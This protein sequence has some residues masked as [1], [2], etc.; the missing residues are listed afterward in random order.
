MD[1]YD[2]DA[3]QVKEIDAE[4]IHL[5]ILESKYLSQEIKKVTDKL[6]L[7]IGAGRGRITK[8][9]LDSKPLKLTCIEK[10]KKTRELLKNRFNNIE[11]KKS[12]DEIY[13][14]YNYII[15]VNTLVHI[16]NKSEVIE[17]IGR[18][19]KSGGKLI[20][21][22]LYQDEPLSIKDS[23]GKE[24]FQEIYKNEFGEIKNKLIDNG[25]KILREDKVIVDNAKAEILGKKNIGR[26]LTHFILAELE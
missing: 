4:E 13:V 8:M 1:F 2:L 23:S 7:E 15:I 19:L 21:S 20:I 18:I 24:V 6:V 22:D 14:K 12:L 5:N 10:S 3:E 11:V 9:I 17:D 26:P 16:K 25:F